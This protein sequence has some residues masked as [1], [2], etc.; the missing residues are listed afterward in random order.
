MLVKERIP[1]TL[2]VLLVGATRVLLAAQMLRQHEQEAFD[3]ANAS[4]QG[5]KSGW[6]SG[7]ATAGV[8]LHSCLP[9]HSFDEK[10]KL[11]GR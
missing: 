9:T 7:P 2:D 11:E 1:S 4:V 6:S 8:S 5:K 3:E 10:T